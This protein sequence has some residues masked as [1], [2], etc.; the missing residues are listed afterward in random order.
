MCYIAGGFLITCPHN[1]DVVSVDIHFD[2][3]D[4]KC[5]PK[6][7]FDNKCPYRDQLLAEI[8]VRYPNF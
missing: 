5:I 6:C 4:F 7:N 8:K 1:N 2:T 3:K